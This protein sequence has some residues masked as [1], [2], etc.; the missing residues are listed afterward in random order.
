[1]KKSDR[2]A[3]VLLFCAALFL[4]VYKMPDLVTFDYDQEFYA[5]EYV[6]IVKEHKL[7]LLGMETSI[8]GMF[9]GPLYTYFSTFVYWLFGGNPLGIFIVTIIVSA[10][11]PSLTYLLFTRLSQQKRI[12]ILGGLLVLFCIPLWSKVYTPSVI[13]FLYPI[14]LVFWYLLTKLQSNKKYLIWIGLLLGLSLHLHF[15]LLFFFPIVLVYVI[16][17]KLFFF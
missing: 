8:G 1:M 17:K 14:G 15:S 13:T 12:G 3:M 11:Y 16:W 7:T 10:T 2:R 6:K 9:V 5:Q 4:Y